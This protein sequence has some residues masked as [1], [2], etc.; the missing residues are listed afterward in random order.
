MNRTLP[1]IVALLGYPALAA[2]GAAA[3]EDWAPLRVVTLKGV[4]QC[5]NYSQA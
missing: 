1:L 2:A 5:Y 4:K 3:A